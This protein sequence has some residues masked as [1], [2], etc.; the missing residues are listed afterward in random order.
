MSEAL[1][2]ASWKTTAAGIAAFVGVLAAQLSAL[3]D[4]GPGSELTTADWGLV[5]GAA[6]IAIGLIFSRDNDKSSEDAGVAGK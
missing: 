6:A 5:A 2:K 3:W 1:K 4:T